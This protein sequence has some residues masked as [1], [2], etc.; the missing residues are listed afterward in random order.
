M[1]VFGI[2]CHARFEN[3]T[4]RDPSKKRIP[5]RLSRAFCPARRHLLRI[6]KLRHADRNICG[7]RCLVQ[8]SSLFPRMRRSSTCQP[9]GGDPKEGDNSRVDVYS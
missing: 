4:R 7:K 6:S 1:S 9:I 5:N 3:T 2:V 8:I